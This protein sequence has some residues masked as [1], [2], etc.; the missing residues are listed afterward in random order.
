MEGEAQEKVAAS[1]QTQLTRM[2]ERKLGKRNLYDIEKINL[3]S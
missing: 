2:L 1:H 3:L